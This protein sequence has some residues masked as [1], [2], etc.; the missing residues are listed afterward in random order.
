MIVITA[1]DMNYKYIIVMVVGKNMFYILRKETQYNFSR[2]ALFLYNNL[3]EYL[4][5]N[6]FKISTYK[7]FV[8]N[9]VVDS[10]HFTI[11]WHEENLKF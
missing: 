10:K 1:P 7:L 11:I 8:A 5:D 2:T 6:G 4:K 9:K 3:P